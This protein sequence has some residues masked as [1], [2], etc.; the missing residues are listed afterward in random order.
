MA[1]SNAWYATFGFFKHQDQTDHPLA[2]E[3]TWSQI[4]FKNHVNPILHSDIEARMKKHPSSEQGGPLY[5]IILMNE[6]LTS[7]ENSLAALENGMQPLDSSNIKIK[8]TT[9]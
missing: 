9:H 2:Q 3:L 1:T 7:N 6:I 8:Q 4:H 5:F